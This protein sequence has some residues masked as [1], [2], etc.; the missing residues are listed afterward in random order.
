MRLADFRRAGHWPSLVCAFLY[1]DVSFMVWVLLGPLAPG[2]AAELWPQPNGVSLDEHLRQTAAWKGV[3]VSVPLL[4]G[5]ILRPVLGV[6]TDRIGARRTGLTGMAL[7]AV[8]LLLG[9]LWADTLAKLVLVGL[10]LGVAGASFAAALPLASRWYP[11]RHQG[12]ALGIAGAGNSGTALATLFGPLLATSLGWRAVFGLAL[13][14]LAVT[15]VVFLLLARDAPEQPR[16]QPPAAFGKVL[17]RP[18]AWWFCFFYGITFGGFVGLASFLTTFF[19]DQYFAADTAAG[20]RVSYL[21][22]A[23]VIAGSFL[24]PVGGY[25]ADRFGGGRVLVR[26]YAGV[27]AVMLGVAALPPAVAAAV[28]LAAGM[29][30]LGMGNGAVFQLVPRRFPREIGVVTGLVGAAGGVGGFFLPNVLGLLKGWTG[31]YG[32]GFMVL[33]AGS[34]CGAAGLWALGWV[35]EPVAT[36]AVEAVG[37][38]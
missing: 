9:W 26:L 21:V 12:L 5:A 2:I 27:A 19:Q 31:S 30:M 14:P 29:G 37:V 6:M 22:T 13:A 28:L 36:P 34:L 38:S 16:P 10:L 15:F 18:D 20:A 11:P 25:L 7:T 35:R 4:G 33:A 3:L 24:R 8:P 23:C 1:F 32:V 17:G